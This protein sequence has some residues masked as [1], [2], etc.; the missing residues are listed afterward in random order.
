MTYN[1]I[2]LRVRAELGD[3]HAGALERSCIDEGEALLS[4]CRAGA[5]R[6]VRA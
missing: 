5:A 2:M 6:A 4:L 3:Y 1:E